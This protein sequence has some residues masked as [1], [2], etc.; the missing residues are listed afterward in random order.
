MDESEFEAFVA[1][2]VNDLNAKQAR[3]STEYGLGTWTD[4]RL[5][6]A[7]RRLSFLD[8]AGVVVWD[9]QIT[10]IGTFR[11]SD[12]TWQWFWAIPSLPE[13]VRAASE[14]LQSLEQVTGF[15]LF[16]LPAM[17]ADEGMPWELAA[18]SVRSLDAM[19]CYHAASGDVE[20]FVAIDRLTAPS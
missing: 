20:V 3:L 11:R 5:D 17:E 14:A 10:P 6:L 18:M 19:G 8:Q 4:Y 12:S 7:A 16:S 1:R 13:D 15:D 2:S 9:A